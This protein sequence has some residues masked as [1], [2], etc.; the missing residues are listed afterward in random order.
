VSAFD[1]TLLSTF[2]CNTTRRGVGLALVLK[3]C[4]TFVEFCSN[5]LDPLLLGDNTHNLIMQHKPASIQAHHGDK[6]IEIR[7]RLWT[8]QIAKTKGETVPKNALDSGVVSLPHNEAH[9]IHASETEKFHSLL[10]LPA[11][12]EKLLIENGIKLHL[13][14]EPQKYY[15]DPPARGRKKPHGS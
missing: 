11:A 10:Q 6:T 8:D 15:D 5:R 9:G 14:R 1:R 7:I 3:S 2:A 12:I 13:S 4:K